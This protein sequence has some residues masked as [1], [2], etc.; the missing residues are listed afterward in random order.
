MIS[1]KQKFLL[2]VFSLFFNLIFINSIALANSTANYEAVQESGCYPNI[3]CTCAEGSRYTEVCKM[4]SGKCAFSFDCSSKNSYETCVSDST[5]IQG[6]FIN[7]IDQVIVFYYSACNWLEAGESVSDF[8]VQVTKISEYLPNPMMS[9]SI[10]QLI[11]KMINVIMGVVGSLALLMF[12]YGGIIWMTAAGSDERVKK[13]KNI[14]VWS[15]LGL[16][17]VFMAYGLTK[18]IINLVA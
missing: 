11:G 12:V 3:S 10:N 15:A 2:L 8:D 7:S 17:A 1:F 13:G 14:L 4:N 6:T 16:I 18:F 9:G 5:R